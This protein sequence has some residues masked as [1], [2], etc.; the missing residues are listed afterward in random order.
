V[1]KA[2]GDNKGGQDR[3]AHRRREKSQIAVTVEFSRLAALRQLG[4]VD[5]ISA[6]PRPC[7][8]GPV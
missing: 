7:G 1:L 8:S 3:S 4:E 2:Y 5:R 6:A